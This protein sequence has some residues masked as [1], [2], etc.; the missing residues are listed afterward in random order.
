MAFSG[1]ATYD[2]GAPPGEEIA[3][4]VSPIISMIA[5][6]ET[7]LLDFLS[8][9]DEP[10]WSTHHEWLDDALFP[11]RSLTTASGASGATA[12][13]VTTGEGKY[14]RA[15]DTVKI[16]KIST[17]ASSS[18]VRDE[19]MLITS[20]STDT[21]TVTRGF[22]GTTAV[23]FALGDEVQRV[24]RGELEGADT[25]TAITDNMSRRSNWCQIFTE[26]VNI[27]G[28]REAVRILGGVGSNATVDRE[29]A[30]R[31]RELLAQ[32]EF[33]VIQGIA[34]ASVEQ[35]SSTVRRFMDGFKVQITSGVIDG[36][37]YS[38]GITEAG[39]NAAFRAAWDKGAKDIDLLLVG[40]YQKRAINSFIGTSNR[41]W[42]PED[43]K[44]KDMVGIY[45]SDYGPAT[46]ML[47]RSVPRDAVMGLSSKRCKVIPMGHRS[48][49]MYKLG[50]TGDSHKQ[51]ILGEYTCE[52]RNGPDGAHFYIGDIPFTT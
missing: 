46:V 49:L 33:S 20:V 44:F 13:P 45:E 48:F 5:R 4:D 52:L 29:T 3:E 23:A 25:P 14:F 6:D 9:G 19:V 31:L 51:A 43:M 10:A 32:L 7:P 2:P 36:S 42:K 27:S 28:T 15:G 38:T 35:G 30:K 34:P 1:K 16:S 17:T 50:K 40:G 37:G 41:W 26:P 22:G 39:L 24:S 18:Y 12:L 47:N 11:N 8:P 21:C